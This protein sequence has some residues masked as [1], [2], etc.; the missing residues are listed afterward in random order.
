V[1]ADGR[2]DPARLAAHCEARGETPVAALP[3]LRW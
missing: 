3:L 2:A 1:D